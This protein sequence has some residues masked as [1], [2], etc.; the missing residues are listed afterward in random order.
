[1]AK[2]SYPIYDTIFLSD[3]AGQLH[4]LFQQGQ[5]TGTTKTPVYTN[6]RGSGQFPDRE[7]FKVNRFGLHID[8]IG[9]S[10]DDIAGLFVNSY[11]TLNYNN[12]KI[13]QVPSYLLSDKNAISGIK[14]E[15]SASAFDYFGQY[16]DGFVLDNPITIQGGKNFNIEFYQSLAVDTANLNVK[17]TM[18][19]ELD[20]PDI[21]VN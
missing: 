3:S 5:G 2:L 8:G 13:F 6:A 1:M 20:S 21:S 16:G 4:T 11:V 18:F 10:D 9:F 12:V 17:L 15:A 19:G 7:T 14:T